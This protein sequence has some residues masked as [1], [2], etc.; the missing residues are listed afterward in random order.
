M[1]PISL[2]LIVLNEDNFIDFKEEQSLNI[3]YISLTLVALNEE[4][5]IDIKE[6]H[7]QNIDD[8]LLTYY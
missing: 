3:L 6:E 4:K 2:T 5:S 1:H 8:I 7:F